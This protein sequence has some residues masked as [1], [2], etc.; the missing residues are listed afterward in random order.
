M[1]APGGSPK[2]HSRA[3]RREADTRTVSKGRAFDKA[4]Q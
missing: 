2:G 1:S 4:E 3:K